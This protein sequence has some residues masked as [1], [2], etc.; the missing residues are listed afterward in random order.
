MMTTIVSGVLSGVD[1]QKQT[2]T[3]HLDNVTPQGIEL[4]K[5]SI[6]REATVSLRHQAS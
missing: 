3:L 1:P 5:A 4:L 2:V 6:C